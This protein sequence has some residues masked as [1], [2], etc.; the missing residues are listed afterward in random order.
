MNLEML[1]NQNK[2]SET[3]LKIKVNLLD[4]Q[5]KHPNRVDLI[6]SMNDSLVKLTDAYLSFK[7]FEIEYRS[8]RK[9]LIDLEG[10]LLAKE[11]EL[12]ELRKQNENLKI[13]L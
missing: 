5:E 12:R 13:A 6:E 2:I 4:I 8:A 1:I 7:D 3:I 10:L 11:F 9:R